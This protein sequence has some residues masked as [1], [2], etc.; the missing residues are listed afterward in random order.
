MKTIKKKAKTKSKV[1][2]KDSMLEEF[3]KSDLSSTLKKYKHIGRW[4]VPGKKDEVTMIALD[5]KNFRLLKNKASKKGI[6]HQNLLRQI[7]Q[8]HLKEY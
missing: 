4:L 6:S 8:D 2:M 7:V 5:P 3:E 1:A